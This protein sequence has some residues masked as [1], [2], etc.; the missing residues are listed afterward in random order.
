MRSTLALLASA[1]GVAA[2]A[3]TPPRPAA[4]TQ[5]VPAASQPSGTEGTLRVLWTRPLKSNSFGGAAVAD[6]DGDGRPDIAFATYFG[7]SS[8]H[9]LSGVD[10]RPLWTWRGDNE[11]LDASLR[12]TDLDGDGKLELVVPVSNTGRVLAFDAATGKLIW[13]RRLDA[14]EC[15]DTPPCIADADGDG[16]PDVI[17]GTFKGK[18]HVI[19]GRDGELLRSL[20]IAP[21]AVQ[22]CPIVMDLNGDGIADFVAANFRGDHCLHAV[23]GKDGKPLWKVQTGSDIY[24]GPSVGDLDGDGEPDMAIGSYDGKVYAFRARDGKPLWTVAPGD[25]YFMSPTAMHDID[26]DGRP[27]VIVAS[28]RVSVIRG[29]GKVLYSV[30]ADE[31]RGM[32]SVTR[33]VSIADMDGNGRADLVVLNSRGLLRVLRARDGRTLYEFDASKLANGPVASNSHGPVIADF[34]GDGRLDAFFV[35]GGDY[36]RQ[37]GAA[38]CLTGFAGSGPGWYMLRH[39]AR[40]TGN[41]MTELEPAL[42]K[43]LGRSAPASQPAPRAGQTD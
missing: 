31:S 28:Q 36:Q 21:G 6:V 16:Q 10:G 33:G 3:Q 39:D 9:V 18:L 1:V 25:R 20:P 26:G 11:C 15:I 35:V 43:R 19:R 2:H 5:P 23:S 41:T 12:F 8:V 40:N 7:D 27:E 32:D 14:G 4:T 42:R 22:S 37:H 30:P 34:D 13:E 29:D 17:V 24:H 38:V